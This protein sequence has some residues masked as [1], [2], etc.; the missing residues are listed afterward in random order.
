V[1]RAIVLGSVAI[2]IA[3]VVA[4]TQCRSSTTTQ[5]REATGSAAPATGSSKRIRDVHVD[6]RTQKRGSI[7]GTITD[8]STKAPIASARVCAD[9][10]SRSLSPQTAREPACVTTDLQGGYALG[11]LV[12][13]EYT[14]TATAPKY[15]PGTHHPG[16]SRRKTRI[17]LAAAETKAAIDIA[18]RGGGVE[19][20]GTVSDVTGGP[21]DG[22]SVRARGNRD[23]ELAPPVESD[24]AGKFSLWVSPGRVRVAATAEGYAPGD[25]WGAA[26]GSFDILLTPESS[27]AGTVIDAATGEPV[28]GVTVTVDSN[29]SAVT[30]RDPRDITDEHGAFRVARLG[31]GRYLAHARAPHGYGMS[32]GSVLVA[33]GQH[34]DGVTIRLHP[35]YRV[36]GTVVRPDGSACDEASVSLSDR[37]AERWA[38][39]RQDLARV[40]NELHADGV[41][42]GTYQVNVRCRGFQSLEKYDP[43]TIVDKDVEH[44]KWQVDPG[45][46]VQGVV[47]NKRGQPVEDANVWARVV[48]GPPRGQGGWGGDETGP[49]GRYSLT[50][51]RAGSY[52][53]EAGSRTTS[54]PTDGWSV[55]V[56]AGSTI[57]KN[58][59]VDDDGSVAGTVVTASGKP[60]A[61]VDVRA[62]SSGRGGGASGRSA[63]DGTFLIEGIRPGDYTIRA[64]RAWSQALRKPGTTDDG[65]QGE[66]AAVTAGKTTTVRLVVED[67]SGRITGTVLDTNGAPAADA[68][69]SAVRES[70]AAGAQKSNVAAARWTYGDKPVITDTSGAFTVGNLSP[71]NYTVRA[72]RRGGGEAFAEH[73]AVGSTTKLQI[74]RTG[75]IAGVVKSTAGTIDELVV[76]LNDRTT[77]F[78]RTERLFRTL[79][80]FTLRDLPAGTF[81]L[82]IS[83]TVGKKE[84]EV[85]LADGE[86]KTGLEVTLEGFVTLT[87]RVVDA[88]TKQAI[89]GITMVAA[90]GRDGRGRWAGRDPDNLNIS[91]DDG[92]FTLKNA[93]TGTITLRGFASG[94]DSE[95]A[96]II[97]VKTVQG[98]GTIEIGDIVA[99]K[100]RVKPGEK[101][102]DLG[103]RFAEAPP[104]TAQD[105]MV[106]KVSFIDPQGP[107]AKTD[108]KVGDVLTAVDGIDIT[109]AASPNAWTLMRAPPGTKL[110]LGLERGATVTIVLVPP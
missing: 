7:S 108:L 85:T 35:A 56:P 57:E 80:Q 96:P 94:M 27:L 75:S 104:G 98:T 100:R 49:D 16:G 40:D 107:A 33:L 73:V 95:Y 44:V 63:A 19:I 31:P 2:V 105:A 93:P 46:T 91:G 67:Q 9:A 51:L 34:V 72:F 55:E 97:L 89:P 47:T 25:A 15:Q 64:Y 20:T 69:V 61:G 24:A 87:G 106:Y 86:S 45:A 53:I 60:V 8:A 109:G 1:K 82:S 21:V 10:W 39:L 18:L 43:I 65:K 50:G 23:D 74:R 36:T 84:L 5:R 81:T 12:A 68:Y 88:T 26:P 103:I 71:G 37:L 99:Y 58:L 14:V 102:G 32:E 54:G 62:Q 22:A 77:G 52:R 3:A 38:E 13:A 28:V 92:R 6:P 11:G 78:S 42:P 90:L 29:D 17:A 48:G 83:S 41:L 76:A 30:D 110:T 70:D 101:A 59:V 66:P 4:I 79:G